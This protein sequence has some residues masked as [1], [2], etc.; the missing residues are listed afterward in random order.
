MP[1]SYKVSSTTFH[2]EEIWGGNKWDNFYQLSAPQR[3]GRGGGSP[4]WA[5]VCLSVCIS[6]SRSLNTESALVSTTA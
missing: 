3:V 1:T 4:V 6:H 2:E 5:S